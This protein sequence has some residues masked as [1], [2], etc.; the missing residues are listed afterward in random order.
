MNFYRDPC[1][2]SGGD[3][4]RYLA[5]GKPI[6]NAEYSQDGEKVSRFCPSDRRW[7]IWGALFSAD[8]NGPGAYEVCWNAVNEL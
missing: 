7:G 6:L 5:A 1:A 2:G 3:W 4:N 8:L